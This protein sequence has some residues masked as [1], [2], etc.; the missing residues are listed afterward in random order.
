[1]IAN[2]MTLALLADAARSAGAARVIA[3]VPY[4]GYSRQ[5]QRGNPCSTTL[6]T[7]W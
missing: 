1:M 7:I 3:V 6:Y 2:F 5:E 4:F